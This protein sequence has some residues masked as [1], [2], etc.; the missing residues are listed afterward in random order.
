[1]AAGGL[2]LRRYSPED[3]NTRRNSH[4]QVGTGTVRILMGTRNSE[5]RTVHH[6][7]FRVRHRSG[8]DCG[9]HAPRLVP[10]QERQRVVISAL[11]CFLSFYNSWLT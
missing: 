6:W 8:S 7:L 5:I 9:G 3:T 11:V 2:R 1:M 10:R 4:L